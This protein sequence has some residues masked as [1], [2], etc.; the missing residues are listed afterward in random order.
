MTKTVECGGFI[1]RKDDT[2][3]IGIAHLCNNPKE[4]IEPSKFM[5]ERFDSLSPLS[6]TPSGQKR[7]TFSYSPFIGGKRICIGMSFAQNVSKVLL[8]SLISHLKFK[9]IDPDFK[10]PY[11]NV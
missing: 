8:P 7:N 4:W 5:P 11:N 3:S 6:L 2:F 1:F 9:A 10:M